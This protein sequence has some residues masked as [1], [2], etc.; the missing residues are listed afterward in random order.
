MAAIPFD[1]SLLYPLFFLL[2]ILSVLFLFW[3]AA[4]HEL[5]DSN[6]AFDLIAVGSIGAAVMARLFDFFGKNDPSSWQLARLL[7]FNRYGSFDFYGALVGLVVAFFVFLR[8]K[9]VNVWSVLDLAAAPLAFG[10]MLVALGAYLSG[11]NWILGSQPLWSFLGYL[12][13]FV[14]LKRLATRKRHPGFFFSFYLVG[15]ATV[16]ILTFGFRR[17]VHWLAKIPYELAAPIL[18]FLVTLAVWYALA[19]RN[20]QEDVKWL[21]GLVLLSIFRTI[22][23][24]KS[25]N[26]SG[27]FSKSIIFFP[28]YVARSV[29]SLLLIIAREVRL[30]LLDFLYVF[31]IRRFLK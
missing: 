10:Q 9:K 30:A 28:Y 19:R 17:E 22:R 15:H 2:A 14:L 16:D 21:S 4:R 23:M 20:L 1:L 25:A 12:L 7:F 3:R 8:S 6:E 5:I 13:L 29:L 24:V 26:E 18:L 27:K 11:G 31:G